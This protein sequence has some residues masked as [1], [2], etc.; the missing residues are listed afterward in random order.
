M[1]LGK[2]ANWVIGNHDQWRVGSRIRAELMDP[3]NLITMTLPGVS[4]T[5]YGEEIGKEHTL[6]NTNYWLFQDIFFRPIGD[7]SAALSNLV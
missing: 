4:V 1:Y 7:F 3:F 6:L 2:K 5:Y